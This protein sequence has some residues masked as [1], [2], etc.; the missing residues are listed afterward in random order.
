MSLQSSADVLCRRDV[1]TTLKDAQ[2][3]LLEF[4][5]T[6][7]VLVGH[8]LENDLRAMRMVHDQIIDTSVWCVSPQHSTH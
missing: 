2:K 6:E 4:V 3:V 7:T 8:G 5:D 1:T